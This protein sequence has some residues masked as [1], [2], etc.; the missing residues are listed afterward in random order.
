[1][2]ITKEFTLKISEEELKEAVEYYMNNHYKQNLKITHITHDTHSFTE[3]YGSMEMDYE[4]AD[5][6]TI[7]AVES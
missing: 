4:E 1:M 5:G 2:N 3:G 7:K 6:L